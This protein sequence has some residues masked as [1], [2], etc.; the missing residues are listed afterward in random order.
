M[1]SRSNRI[2]P[3]DPPDDWV[4]GSWTV[5]CICGVNFDD[6]EEMVNCD[7]C[8]VWVHTRC[9]RFTKGEKSF[10]CDKCKNKSSRNNDSEETEVA[11]LLVELPTKPV[12]TIKMGNNNSHSNSISH[13]SN[14]NHNSSVYS[15]GNHPPRR[16]PYRLWVNK[17]MEERVH[18]QGVPGGD[19]DPSLFKGFPLLFASELW[20]CTGYV[21]KKFNF[22]YKEFPC[23]GKEEQGVEVEVEANA[24]VEGGTESVA[25]KG[26]GVLYSLS[27]E[28]VVF[29]LRKDQG[30]SGSDR[31]ASKDR[32]WDNGDSKKISLPSL[33]KKEK[34]PIVV[35]CSS[36]RS[37][38]EMGS[39]KDRSGKKKI[40]AIR[41]EQ[42]TKK[43]NGIGLKAVVHSSS[44]RQAEVCENKAYK[45]ASNAHVAEGSNIG[46]PK[47]N[48]ANDEG[49]AVLRSPEVPIHGSSSEK[50]VK[51]ENPVH[52]ATDCVQK[53]VKIEIAPLPFADKNSTARSPIKKEGLVL[54]ALDDNQGLPECQTSDILKSK[55]H[56][57]D[58]DN[59]TVEHSN[60]KD[61]ETIVP[62]IF[63]H[64]LS[65]TKLDRV[66]DNTKGAVGS[67]PSDIDTKMEAD[68]IKRCTE[69][70]PSPV[71][72]CEDF[73]PNEAATISSQP[74]EHEIEGQDDDKPL[75]AVSGSQVVKDEGIIENQCNNKL[76]SEDSE[77]PVQV[78]KSFSDS[79]EVTK[80]AGETLKLC[81]EILPPPASYHKP[82]SV[83]KSSPSSS[84]IVISRSSLSDKNR[85][86]SSQCPSSIGKRVTS[87]SSMG[88]K[89][90]NALLD[91][92]KDEDKY[93]KTKSMLKDHSKSSTIPTS[94]A[95]QP[96]K[97]VT[98]PVLN[99]HAS[100]GKDSLRHPFSKKTS[101]EISGVDEPGGVLQTQHASNGQNKSIA[102][103]GQH[104]NE[105]VLQS[106]LQ[107]S[108]KSTQSSSGHPPPS[109]NTPAGLSD[110]ELALLLHQE[111]NSSPRVPRVPRVR[112]TGNLPQVSSAS[113]T[114][115][116]IKR[117]TSSGGKDQYTFSRRKTKD[118]PRSSRE[119]DSEARKADR[120]P[121]SPDSVKTSDTLTHAEAQSESIHSVR[122]NVDD[123]S[124]SAVNSGPS[125][126]DANKLKPSSTRDLSANN[127]EG[128]T[129][130]K[131]LPLIHR[132]LPGLIAEIMGAGRRMTYEE[133]CNAVLPHWQNLRKHN[134]ERYA[135]SSHSQAVLDCLRNRSEWARLVDRGPKTNASRK[136]RKTDVDPPNTESEDG[137]DRTQRVGK[138]KSFESNKEE[139]PKGRRKARKRRRLA[140]RGR[141][142]R[143]D[144]KRPKLQV[145]S[146]DT[147]SLSN[148]SEDS[149]SS[150]DDSHESGMC[151]AKSEVSASSADMAG[152]Q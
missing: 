115:I 140:L 147:G 124:T 90:D 95:S 110:E 50:R 118:G 39:S 83:G 10:A 49:N 109:S 21:P 101:V 123:N 87:N 35:Q 64:S 15:F 66:V 100:V 148:S 133:L 76:K 2:P 116:F 141:G 60:A 98:S 40:K 132:T 46:K 6:G 25:D 136:K 52:N 79:T 121:S 51:T 84:T 28:N 144:R 29:S 73:K 91:Q 129:G 11:Q 12:K 63:E 4:D 88:T 135:Y 54:D 20:K 14:H 17:P 23:W 104:R 80:A 22:S 41:R 89:K 55:P 30:G 16:P 142:V 119:Q 7:E 106:N 117:G 8:S 45:M 24:K 131:C 139:Y 70:L 27:K 145:G 9:F 1:K 127:A 71:R 134:G 143:D 151:A 74:H 137:E 97:S 38:E 68:G 82:V 111:L 18:V 65:K 102:S 42:D 128:D 58:V 122:K 150:E 113:P 149:G 85:A 125:S 43:D 19:D 34:G 112:H 152:A 86:G 3:S 93:E 99:R 32:K 105:K 75:E 77:N 5:D 13:H 103:G 26:A 108:S 69:Q 120:A 138:S 59:A 56:S 146:D 48:A 94:K 78:Q 96:S 57:E 44:A 81:G 67:R 36:K 53:S 114:S 126:T 47:R 72:E 61:V 37:R 31:K 33:S 130:T 92:V 62:L 107:S